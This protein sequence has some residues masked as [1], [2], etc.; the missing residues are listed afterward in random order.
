MINNSF[1]VG[2]GFF[3]NGQVGYIV[4]QICGYRNR[5]R[6]GTKSEVQMGRS[7]TSYRTRRRRYG[8]E[9]KTSSSGP[10]TR[11]LSPSPPLFVHF[12]RVIVIHYQLNPIPRFATR[13]SHTTKM[14]PPIWASLSLLLWAWILGLL[15]DVLM[16]RT[17]YCQL[18]LDPQR[19]GW[20]KYMFTAFEPSSSC[21]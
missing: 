8:C 3:A 9:E 21:N 10:P 12:Q 11:G 13:S 18:P 19:L 5:K 6:T 2:V 1:R 14:G 20:I 16:G 15:F 7:A 4:S 17:L